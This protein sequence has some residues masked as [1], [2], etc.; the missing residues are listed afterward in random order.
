MGRIA[1]ILSFIRSTRKSAKISDVKIDTGGGANITVEHFSTPG[2]DSHPLKTDY[3]I[4]L[5]T[6]QS[7]GAV[8][9]GYLDPANDQKANEGDKRIYS[10]DATGVVK[11][12]IW[13]KNDGSIECTNGNGSIELRAGGN[14]LLNGVTIAADG[15]VTIPTSLNLNG[16]EIAE[17]THA[18]TSGSSAP[19]PTGVNN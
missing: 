15:T 2:D 14:I 3:V 4:T 5:E 12:E 9:V 17:H 19:G 6:P 16:K 11:A 10:R 1:R 13:L 18:I 8:A 7:G